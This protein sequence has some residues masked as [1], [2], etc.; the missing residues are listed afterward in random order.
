MV[1]GPRPGD[2]K[3][4]IPSPSW[5]CVL[6]FLFLSSGSLQRPSP[7]PGFLLFKEGGLPQ[8]PLRVWHPCSCGLVL[9]GLHTWGP[10]PLTVQSVSPWNVRPLARTGSLPVCL[11]HIL[12]LKGTL[13]L[14]GVLDGIP[15]DRQWLCGLRNQQSVAPNPDPRASALPHQV[16]PGTPPL[17]YQCHTPGLVWESRDL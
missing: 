3:M 16:P 6:R 5:D 9:M 15:R 12:G 2:R 7:G 14:S 17:S 11:G 10:S 1:S 4:S 8:G 13:P